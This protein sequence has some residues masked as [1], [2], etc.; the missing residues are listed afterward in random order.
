MFNHDYDDFDPYEDERAEQRARERR[1]RE[2][3]KCATCSDPDSPYFCEDP[4]NYLDEDY[5][6]EEEL[7]EAEA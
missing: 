2:Y 4:N 3:L 7:E 1:H 6:E 5:T